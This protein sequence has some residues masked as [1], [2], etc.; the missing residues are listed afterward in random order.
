MK[1]RIKSCFTAK[2]K[3]P[4]YVEIPVNSL[5][6]GGEAEI[7][8]MK[9]PYFPPHE[10][11][12]YLHDEVNA[13]TPRSHVQ[14]YYDWGRAFGCGWSKLGNGD[15]I[16]CGIYAD[17]TNYG[18]D[19]NPEK[20]LAIYT[21]FVLW[22]PGSV[23]YSRV[24]LFT[25]RSNLMVGTH[26]LYPLLQKIVESCHYAFRGQNPDGTQLCRDPKT[27]FLVTELRGDLAWQKMVWECRG[28]WQAHD[29]CFFCCARSIGNQFLYT[30]FRYNAD[31]RATE[32]HDVWH[33]A[34]EVLPQDKLCILLASVNLV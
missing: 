6:E 15:M 5:D 25:M 29:C 31:W 30:D 8:S 9:L 14:Y 2:L 11:W 28:G 20:V 21:N 34:G 13:K 1:L 18:L 16:P 4:S 17:E 33:W 10:V 22:R 24:L 32:F 7:T 26:S 12:R 27:K 19:A 3:A 23:R